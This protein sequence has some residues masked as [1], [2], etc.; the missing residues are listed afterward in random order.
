MN[1]QMNYSCSPRAVFLV[2]VFLSIVALGL[3][4]VT[5]AE[6]GVAKWLFAVLTGAALLA[7][8]YSWHFSIRARRE[9]YVRPLSFLEQTVVAGLLTITAAVFIASSILSKQYWFLFIWFKPI[10]QIWIRASDK[11]QNR[12][13]IMRG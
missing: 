6:I 11:R 2:A 3:I 13:I 5:R 4:P 1:P 8:V 10:L 12:V 7:T 9:G